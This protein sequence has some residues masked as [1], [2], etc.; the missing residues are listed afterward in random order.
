MLALASLVCVHLPSAPAVRHAVSPA[1]RALPVQLQ[2]QDQEEKQSGFVLPFLQPA[3]PE[4]QQVQTELRELKKQ[5][6]MDWPTDDGYNG[7]LGDLYQGISLFVSL[8]IAYTTFYNLPGELPNLFVAANLG[9]VVAMVP[10][11]LRLRVGWGFVSQ[12]LRER[13]TYYEANQRGLFARKDKAEVLRDRLVEQ[14]EVRPVLRRIDAS[15]AGLALAL[16]LSVGSTEVVTALQGESGPATLKTLTG[17]E[18]RRFDNRLKGDDEFAAEQQRRAQTRNP[19][20]IK[21]AYCDSRYYK[22]L[23]GGNGQGGVGCGGQ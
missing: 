21:P 6:F 14:Q 12:R 1:R 23:A 20:E 15:L 5:K 19:D 18:A 22:I 4:D 13:Q 3:V 7:R 2:Q 16:L 9:T 11:V 8:P 17:D 10:F